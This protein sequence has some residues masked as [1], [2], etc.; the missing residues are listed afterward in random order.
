MSLRGAWGAA[1]LLLLTAAPGIARTVVAPAGKAAA[2]IAAA[3]AGDTVV[4]ARGVH[5]GPLVLPKAIVLRGEPGAVVDGHGS[6]SVVTVGA[7]GAVVEDLALR[8]TGRSVMRIDA[9]VRVVIGAG[10]RL[11]RRAITHPH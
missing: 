5:D 6:G 4:L 7:S 11:S 9:A 2:A 1:L 3:A 10:V 8:G